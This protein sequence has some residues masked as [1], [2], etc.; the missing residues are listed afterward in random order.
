VGCG[1]D[2]KGLG[3]SGYFGN[4]NYRTVDSKSFVLYGLALGL[5]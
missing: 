3:F 4:E 1:A 2:G 5:T